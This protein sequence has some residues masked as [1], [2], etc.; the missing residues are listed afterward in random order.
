MDEQKTWRTRSRMRTSMI[1]RTRRFAFGAALIMSMVVALTALPANAQEKEVGT[2]ERIAELTQR[3]AETQERLQLTDEQIEQLLPL[4]KENLQTTKTVLEEHGIDLQNRTEG[5]SDR[6]PSLR[7]LRALD[8]DLD[9]VREA[10]LDKIEEL[11]F[12]SDEQFSEFK[13]VQKEQRKALRGRLRDRND[14]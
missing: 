10:L 12:L 13:K 7:K 6:R 14:S 11:G 5:D 1:N 3:L 9:D 8:R 4:L 2:D